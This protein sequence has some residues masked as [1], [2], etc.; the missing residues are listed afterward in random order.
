[1][2]CVKGFRGSNTRGDLWNILSYNVITMASGVHVV[3]MCD[4]TGVRVSTRALHR[5]QKCITSFIEKVLLKYAS[6][7]T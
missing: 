7:N 5:L 1:M 3:D 2:R 4:Y 6:L